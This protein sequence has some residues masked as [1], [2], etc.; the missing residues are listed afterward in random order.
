MVRVIAVEDS[1]T[2]V[3]DRNRIAERVRL[4]DVVVSRDEESA[5]VDYLNKS[6]V[7]SWVLVETN[8]RGESYVYRSPD[9]LSVNGALSRR[10]YFEGGTRMTYLGEANPGPQRTV[11]VPKASSPASLLPPAKP[12]RA[13][14]TPQGAHRIPRLPGAN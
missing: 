5:A 1:R 4:A 13:R 12:R 14:T 9:A 7:G 2:I 10:A 11:T 3:V 6:V 8:A